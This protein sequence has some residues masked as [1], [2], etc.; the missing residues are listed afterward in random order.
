M[1]LDSTCR[2]QLKKRC[3][4]LCLIILLNFFYAPSTPIEQKLPIVS[5]SISR[6]VVI[7][8]GSCALFVIFTLLMLGMYFLC[9]IKRGHYN[10]GRTYSYAIEDIKGLQETDI[11]I[12][13]AETSIELKDIHEDHHIVPYENGF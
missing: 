3:S 12:N 6:L 9:Q 10:L 13:S 8:I 7:I 5:K 11:R 1:V 2:F 4:S